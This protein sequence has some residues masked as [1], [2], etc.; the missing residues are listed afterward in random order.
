MYFVTKPG[1]VSV[2]ADGLMTA[3]APGTTTVTIINGAAEVV[4][5][6]KVQIPQIGSVA[7]GAEGAVVQGSDGSMVAVPPGVL[8][9][10]TTVSITPAGPADLPQAL[11]N[12][13]QYAA[14]FNL[15]IGPD[16][17]NVPVQL[18]IKVDPSVAAGTKVYF[19][20]AGD[21]LN[22]DGTTRPIWWQVE[23]GIVGADGYAHTN[24]PPYSG[25]DGKSLYMVAYGNA[26]LATL[27]LQ[28]AQASQA[29]FS[30]AVGGDTGGFMGAFASGNGSVLATLAVPSAPEPQPFLLQV[31]TPGN[32][33][34]TTRQTIRSILARL[35]CSRPTLRRRRL[36][37]RTPRRLPM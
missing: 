35:T 11:P 7:V 12:G 16:P 31:L 17:L 5:P 27:Q 4:V 28:Q 34:V 14:A 23:N 19:F 36:F 6:V 10:T 25:V 22:D 37:Q 20:Q 13:F 8:T 30:V 32:L 29:A 18:A 9:S 33:P 2:S 24:S 26:N 1:V 15:D 3:I 21:Y